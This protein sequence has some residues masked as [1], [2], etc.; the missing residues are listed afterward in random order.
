MLLELRS[1]RLL[2]FSQFGFSCFSAMASSSSFIATIRVSLRASSLSMFRLTL[3]HRQTSSLV[4]QTKV[5]RPREATRSL[6]QPEGPQAS[7]TTRSI[8]SFLKTVVRY[9]RSGGSGEKVILPG[10][11]VIE[12]AH[13][14]ELAEV[15][16]ENVHLKP[17]R[18]H[19]VKRMWQSS[20]SL[21]RS[22]VR[23]ASFN[24]NGS[25]PS[26]LGLT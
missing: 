25:H 24:T 16:S 19:W 21:L 6:I 5:L 22:R 10:G 8:F 4:E 2:L 9:S 18:V 17:V 13:G 23:V 3:A 14:V 15:Q 26:N 11:G 7:M 12:A 1:N 20:Y